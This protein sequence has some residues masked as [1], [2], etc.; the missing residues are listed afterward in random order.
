MAEHP[1]DTVSRTS[2]SAREDAAVPAKGNTI[3]L[4]SLWEVMEAMANIYVCQI[5]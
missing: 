2:A 5:P 1:G 3:T 4:L